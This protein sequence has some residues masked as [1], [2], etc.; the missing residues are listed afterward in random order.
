M[1]TTEKSSIFDHG[2][3]IKNDPEDLKI[4]DLLDFKEVLKNNKTEREFTNILK[5]A[6][7]INHEI[8]ISHDF[9]LFKLHFQ[10]NGNY[11]FCLK[12][13]GS[14]KYKITEGYCNLFYLP[15]T[16]TKYKQIKQSGKSIEIIF[17][18]TYLE[19][20]I[21]NA[22]K[23]VFSK[24]EVTKSI[25]KPFLLWKKNQVISLNLYN[26]IDDITNCKYNG[27]FKKPYLEAKIKEL[28]IVI[29]S[30]S[31][32]K[33]NKVL[34]KEIVKEDYDKI[35]ELE[36]YIQ[37]NL[38]KTLTINELA[39]FA[40]MNTSKLKQQFKIVYNS[41]VFKYIT[42]QRMLKAKQ[43][44]INKNYSI[45]EAS[46]KVGYKNPQH[47]TAAFKKLYNYLPSKLTDY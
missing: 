14:S 29:L 22:Y 33:E 13:I 43:L 1:K 39:I 23:E 28:L 10:L 38:N 3:F 2:V 9:P 19:Q 41:T 26:I 40:G 34:K 17:S 31:N 44:I 11:E 6:N 5:K 46:Y 47:F 27:S 36:N 25:N 21:G 16:K 12:T 15:N 35:S 8:E 45:K 30:D 7:R 42:E 37:S 4:I 32:T 18:K 20:V 24:H